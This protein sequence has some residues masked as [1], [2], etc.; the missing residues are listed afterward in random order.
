MDRKGD[1]LANAG[2]YNRRH[3][4]VL[5]AT[6]KMV[7]AVAVGACVLGDKGDPEKTAALNEGHA[8]DLAELEGD[9]ASGGDCLV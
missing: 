5:R 4:A 1:G 6:H 3:N 2:E 7:A 8:V 9:D